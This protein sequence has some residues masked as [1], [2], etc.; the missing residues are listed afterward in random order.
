[1]GGDAHRQGLF[2]EFAVRFHNRKSRGDG[3]GEDPELEALI[4]RGIGRLLSKFFL[5]LK[6]ICVFG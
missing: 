5:L 2:R 4:P 3:D 1:M 6:S